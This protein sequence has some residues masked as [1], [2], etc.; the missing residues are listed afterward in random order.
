MVQ[1]WMMLSLGSFMSKNAIGKALPQDFCGSVE[2]RVSK[3]YCSVQWDAGVCQGA[4]QCHNSS[5]AARK[6]RELSG[7]AA[8][9]NVDRG[10]ASKDAVK[11]L[12]R[13]LQEEPRVNGPTLPFRCQ[14]SL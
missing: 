3:A 7:T 10:S 8:F 5:V 14:L 13:L 1:P 11:R 12:S 9:S 4:V 6:H 2:A